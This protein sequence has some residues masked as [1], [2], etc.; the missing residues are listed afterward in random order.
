MQPMLRDSVSWVTLLNF[1]ERPL[2]L[3]VIIGFTGR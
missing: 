2:I 1:F 3:Y